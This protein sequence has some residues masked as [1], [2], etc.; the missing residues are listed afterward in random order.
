MQWNLIR[1]QQ[2]KKI[3]SDIC[4]SYPSLIDHKLSK[5][6]ILFMSDPNKLSKDF[7]EVCMRRLTGLPDTLFYYTFIKRLKRLKSLKV[8]WSM[9]NN[10]FYCSTGSS[11]QH[12][13][14]DNIVK[15]VSCYP[16]EYRQLFKTK[17]REFHDS[18]R[19]I[20]FLMHSTNESSA[21]M[22]KQK[23]LK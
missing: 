20:A 14:K 21:E 22:T 23:T 18:L 5:L 11:T 19:K 4:S 16:Y 6:D 17:I 3:S 10:I 9:M 15:K 7:H 13:C 8:Q 1:F 2:S 12:N